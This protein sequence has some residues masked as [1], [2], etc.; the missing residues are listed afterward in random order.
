LN[1]HIADENVGRICCS[2]ILSTNVTKAGEKMSLLL[3]TLCEA[4]LQHGRRPYFARIF[5]KAIIDFRGTYPRPLTLIHH[6]YS[7]STAT[8]DQKPIS[9]KS[10]QIDEYDSERGGYIAV[11]SEYNL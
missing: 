10:T 4:R 8:R 1:C 9:Q 11:V 5:A 7:T 6:D 2:I 3:R